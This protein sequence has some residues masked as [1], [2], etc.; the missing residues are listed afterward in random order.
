METR[1]TR[2]Y[3]SLPLAGP[4]G[5]AGRDILR[6]A[7]L[8]LERSDGDAVELVA[9][10]TH[11][12][13]REGRAAEHARLAAKDEHA[14]AYL[15]DFHSSQVAA[16]A[17]ILSAAGL[18]QV[19]PAATFAGL[20]GPTLVR[21]M[22]SDE[23]LARGIADW[24]VQHARVSAL[25]VV[26]DH[27]PGYGDPVGRMCAN[28]AME[29]G[30]ETR[31]RPVWNQ[32]EGRAGDLAGVEAVLYVG[33]PGPGTSALWRD[34]HVVNPGMWLLATDG[35]AVD[36]LARAIDADAARMTLFFT[37]QRAPWGFYG[38]EA[39]ALILDAVEGSGGTREGAV[40]AARGTHDRDSILGRYSIDEHGLTTSP[41]SGRLVIS[42]GELVWERA[43]A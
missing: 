36:W 16:T 42:A 39:M 37:A 38:Y 24:L 33:V 4:A 21:L 3:A 23:G 32:E 6:G 29:R 15:G 25:L 14:L 28:A 43:Q 41:A 19:A 35:L 9:L 5:W 40:S 11:T 12:A 7:E 30:I 26:H 20:G 31:S 18:L 17:P 8:A 34:L 1:T 27:D 13:D 10:D 22:P 2:V